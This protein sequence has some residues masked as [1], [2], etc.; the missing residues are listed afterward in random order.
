LNDATNENYDLL[1]QRVPGGNNYF[2]ILL[3]PT[4]YNDKLKGYNDVKEIIGNVPSYV[5]DY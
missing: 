5:H 4:A 3:N 1:P 2:I